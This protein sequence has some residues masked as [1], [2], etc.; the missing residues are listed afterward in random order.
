MRFANPVT[1]SRL[2]QL[3]CVD[4]SNFVTSRRISFSQLIAVITEGNPN[5]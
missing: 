1:L 3:G 4:G 2:R 5:V